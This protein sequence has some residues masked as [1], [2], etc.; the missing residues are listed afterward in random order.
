MSSTTD[1]TRPAPTIDAIQAARRELSGLVRETPAWTW[2]G[3]RI[4]AAKPPGSTV[5]LK[6]ELLQHTGSFKVRGALLTMRRLD[7]AQ[8]ARGVTAVSGGNHAMAVAYAA[9]ALGTHAKVV[10]PAT[11]NPAR[12]A[13]CR[14]L[15]AEVEL[16]ADV[17]VAFARAREIEQAEGRTLVHPF[18]GEG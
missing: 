11:A 10:M 18:E 14:A 16:V 5:W 7:S 2:Q 4:D 9:K 8:L 6:L 15:G 3:H 13:A 12:I 17:A 1:D